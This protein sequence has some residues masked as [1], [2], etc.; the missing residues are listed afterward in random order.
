MLGEY[1]LPSHPNFHPNNVYRPQG[2][3]FA[4]AYLRHLGQQLVPD[5]AYS[6]PVS[7]PNFDKIAEELPFIE[8]LATVIDSYAPAST[9][10]LKIHLHSCVGLIHKLS[11]LR[12]LTELLHGT[13]KNYLQLVKRPHQDLPLNSSLINVPAYSEF[14]ASSRTL[15]E[16]SKAQF[17]KCLTLLE[18]STVFYERG[19]GVE[20]V[21]WHYADVQCLLAEYTGRDR[22]K[23]FPT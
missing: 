17:K 3:Q 21:A 2:L 22:P 19:M 4:R 9:E 13:P 15:L 8:Q 6:S 14:I 18:S 16:Q 5:S 1:S 10:H 23:Y 12:G 20:D 7:L 11:F